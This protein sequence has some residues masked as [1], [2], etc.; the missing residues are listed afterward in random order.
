MA[1][2]ARAR[3][4]VLLYFRSA[5]PYSVTTYWTQVRGVVTTLPGASCGTILEWRTPALSR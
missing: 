1:I 2:S 4:T 3:S 5:T